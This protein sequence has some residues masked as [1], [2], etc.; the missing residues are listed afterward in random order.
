MTTDCLPRLLLR[1]RIDYFWPWLCDLLW[2]MEYHRLLWW[3]VYTYPLGLTLMGLCPETTVLQESQSGLQKRTPGEARWRCC[4]WQPAGPAG[5]LS[6][7]KLTLPHT[8]HSHLVEC[9][10]V[11]TKHN[12]QRSYRPPTKLWKFYHIFIISYCLLDCF[13]IKDCWRNSWDNKILL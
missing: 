2:P 8:H 1:D 7:A 6:K 4:S 13:A 12:H 3:A 10:C 5:H 9:S 11:N